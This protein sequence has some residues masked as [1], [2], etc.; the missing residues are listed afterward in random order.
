MD[1]REIR[2]KRMMGDSRAVVIAVDH[3]FFD[4][5]IDGM[6]DLPGT[7]EK[8]R[9]DVDAV[10]VAP[11]MLRHC[12]RLFAAPKRPLALVRLNWN[13]VYC[14]K[15]NYLK[16]RSIISHTAE[17]ALREGMDIALVSLTLQTGDE[18]HDAENVEVFSRLCNDCHR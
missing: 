13:T 10:L 9:H 17:Q 7:C 11:G 16:A 6:T 14:F 4:G 2:L 5:P 18:I 15:F 8:I 1:A 3:G 12:S